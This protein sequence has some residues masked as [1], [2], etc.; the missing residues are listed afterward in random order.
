MSVSRLLLVG[1]V[2][3]KV[4]D[5]VGVVGAVEGIEGGHEGGVVLD[6]EVRVG[7]EG[8]FVS[9]GESE[10]RHGRGRL[11]EGGKYKGRVGKAG[12]GPGGLIMNLEL[13]LSKVQKP[14]RKGG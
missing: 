4:E 12:G 3:V 9:T 2:F 13:N 8:V 1:L 6:G 14:F 7:V 11:T 10:R 5:H